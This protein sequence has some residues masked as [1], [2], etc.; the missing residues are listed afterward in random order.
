MRSTCLNGDS[1]LQCYSIEDVQSSPDQI[2]TF[3][4]SICAITRI[5]R[6]SALAAVVQER[7]FTQ[8]ELLP[9]A[10]VAMGA[11]GTVEKMKV[12]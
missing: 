4:A 2:I 9:F 11:I 7:L 5:T 6:N 12:K 1:V 10:R 8:M 3:D